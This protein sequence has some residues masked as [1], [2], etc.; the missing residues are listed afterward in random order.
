MRESEVRGKA[1]DM[2]GKEGSFVEACLG[3][4]DHFGERRGKS[5]ERSLQLVGTG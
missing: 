3:K 4:K 2:R 5:R 1:G